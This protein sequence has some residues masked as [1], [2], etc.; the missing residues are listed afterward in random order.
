MRSRCEQVV[1]GALPAA[2]VRARLETVIAA[3]GL[4]LKPETVEAIVSRA[5]GCL[6]DA[7]KL[8][9]QAATN[10]AA[11]AMVGG[12]EVERWAAMALRRLAEGDLPG[13]LDA[14][15]MLLRCAQTVTG[16][17]AG[18]LQ[19]LAEQIYNLHLVMQLQA[20]AE[21]VRLGE[22]AWGSLAKAARATTPEKVEVW[23]ELI[24]EAWGRNKGAL[25]RA[26]A[27]LGLTLVRMHAARVRAM[28][29]TPPPAVASAVPTSGPALADA[30][31]PLSLERMIAA[32]DP[33]VAG[34][35]AKATLVSADGGELVLRCA[36][37]A[38]RKRLKTLAEQVLALAPGFQ[39][40]EVVA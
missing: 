19:A 11:L 10:E 31:G 4:E 2:D 25:M 37:L 14:G 30:G 15:Q 6:R 36:S 26:D 29:V 7:L 22:E 20:T 17:A 34:L 3:E 9:Q 5:D 40:L 1:F 18:A 16:E 23:T 8:L 33:N 21:T 27:L 32:A 24:W 28:V 13:A 35:L 38:T 12:A 39:D